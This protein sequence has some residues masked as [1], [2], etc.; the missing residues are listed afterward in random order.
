M[1]S[2]VDETFNDSS[3]SFL[4]TKVNPFCFENTTIIKADSLIF[5]SVIFN[6]IVSPAAAARGSGDANEG[7][8]ERYVFN[9]FAFVLSALWLLAL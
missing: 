5:D 2:K 9:G 4:N 1:L 7:R 6:G 8:V 3:G